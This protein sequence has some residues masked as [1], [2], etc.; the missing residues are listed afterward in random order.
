MKRQPTEW[1]DTFA[2]HTSHRRER[3]HIHKEPSQL[4]SKKKP[5]KNQEKDLIDASPK[6]TQNGQFVGGK[7]LG[8]SRHREVQMETVS[9]LLSHHQDSCFKK[10]EDSR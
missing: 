5:I 4:K 10:M 3:P 7:V 2:N 9:E 1:E 8:I 6:E